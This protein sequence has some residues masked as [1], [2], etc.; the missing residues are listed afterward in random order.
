M[1]KPK[2]FVLAALLIAIGVGLFVWEPE[3][4]EAE[5]AKDTGRT[6]GFVDEEKNCPISVESY[7]RIREAASGP[8]WDNI[9]GLVLVLGGVG[10]AAVGAFRKPKTEA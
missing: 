7:E 8:R 9:G 3:E 1:T 5:C 10:V 2:L 6:S 4:P